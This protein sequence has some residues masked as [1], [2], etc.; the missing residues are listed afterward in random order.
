MKWQTFLLIPLGLFRC[1]SIGIREPSLPQSTKALISCNMAQYCM[2]ECVLC[3]CKCE[4]LCVMFESL[5]TFA[6]MYVYVFSCVSARVSAWSLL[7]RPLYQISASHLR[8]SEENGRCVFLLP[9]LTFLLVWM[10]AVLCWRARW[11]SLHTETS[12]QRDPCP[13]LL[14]KRSVTR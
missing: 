11:T 3:V 10:M 14:E 12:Q 5:H 4:R 2:S 8:G 7:T 13:S 9:L 1:N 6:C